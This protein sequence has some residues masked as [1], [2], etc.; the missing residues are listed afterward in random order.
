MS[1]GVGSSGQSIARP[2]HETFGPAIQE[3]GNPDRIYLIQRLVETTKIPANHDAI[4]AD[5][6]KRYRGL[7]RWQK[8]VMRLEELILQQKRIAEAEAP[9]AKEETVKMKYGQLDVGN[10]YRETEDGVL[11]R[12]IQADC[13]VCSVPVEEG[14]SAEAYQ[15]E[16]ELSVWKVVRKTK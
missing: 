16:P 12:K 13:F 9:E 11:R 15:S 10:L 14:A 7:S 3:G 4:I 8:I 2:F 1:R 6:K 5:I